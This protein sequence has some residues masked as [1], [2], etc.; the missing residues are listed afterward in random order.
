MSP[1]CLDNVIQVILFRAYKIMS[2]SNE[3][4][5]TSSLFLSLYYSSF[6][7]A[8]AMVSP[9]HR[10]SKRIK[11]MSSPRYS[12]RPERL[13]LYTCTVHVYLIINLILSLPPSLSSF[14]SPLPPSLSSPITTCDIHVHV[15]Y[16]LHLFLS[17]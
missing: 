14:P 17:L 16:S 13:V 12:E 5:T 10:S 6:P 4:I 2:P 15:F 9:T 11:V 7:L 8:L 3:G 1:S